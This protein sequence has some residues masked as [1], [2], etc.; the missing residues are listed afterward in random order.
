MFVLDSLK[1]GRQLLQ[2]L[3]KYNPVNEHSYQKLPFIVDLPV[4]NGDSP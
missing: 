3:Q 2:R 1:P 4:K